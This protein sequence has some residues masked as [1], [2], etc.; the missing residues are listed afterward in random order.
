VLHIVAIETM[1][2]ARR[3]LQAMAA[4]VPDVRLLGCVGAVGPTLDAFRRARPQVVLVDSALD[5][6]TTV[7]RD[8]VTRYPDLTVVA[9]VDNAQRTIGYVAAARTAG[10]HGVIPKTASAESLFGGIRRAHVTRRFVDAGLTEAL[11]LPARARSASDPLSGR[12]RE[13]LALIAQGLD[14]Q[15]MAEAL[16]VSPETVRTHAKEILHRLKARHRAHAVARG[17][18]LGLLTTDRPSSAGDHSGLARPG[19]GPA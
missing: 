3:G 12:Q 14:S 5:P 6:D 7:I 15:E 8:L 13:V 1:P 16:Y 9:W 10:A 4:A 19:R 2:V 11:N 18:D 17:F